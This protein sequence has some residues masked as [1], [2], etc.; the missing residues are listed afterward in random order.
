MAKSP[1]HIAAKGAIPARWPAP[2]TLKRQLGATA[3]GA[4]RLVIDQLSARARASGYRVRNETRYRIWNACLAL[5]IL[6]IMLP[7]MAVITLAL[8][9]TQGNPFYRGIRLGKDRRVFH[10]YKFRTLVPEA[11]TATATRVLRSDTSLTTPL[12]GFLRDVRLDE[13]PQLINVIRGDMN[14]CGPRPVRPAIASICEVQIPNYGDRFRVRPGMI[15]H[16]QVF[17]SHGTPKR[18]RSAYHRILMRRP[19]NV[20][21]ELA[22]MAITVLSLLA[23][24]GRKLGRR[25]R[26]LAFGPTGGLPAC[27]DGA[28]IAFKDLGGEQHEALLK[29]VTDNYLYFESPVALAD[30]ATLDARVSCKIRGGAKWRHARIAGQPTRKRR[31]TVDGRFLYVVRFDAR[32]DYSRHVVLTY[33]LCRVVA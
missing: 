24:L 15:G 13:L 17:M 27:P 14:L 19:A 28:K 3:S 23:K 31:E 1:H 30:G 22:L 32:S 10:I 6:V 11:A 33:F 2:A 4:L 26:R 9:V 12:G 25:V 8:A 20:T 5:A 16:P 7:L 29:R 21:C 18:I